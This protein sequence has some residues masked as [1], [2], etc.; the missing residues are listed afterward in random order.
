MNDRSYTIGEL[1]RRSGI[2][3]R[4]IRFYAD[5]GLLSPDRTEARYRVFTDRDLV[6][7]DLIRA[8]RDAGAGLPAI[9]SVIEEDTSL[10]ELLAVRLADVEA[11]ILRQKALAV[12]LRLAL[13]S[14]QPT[15][16][17]IQ[18]ISRMIGHSQSQRHA[19]ATAFL[20]TMTDGVRFDPRWHET[21]IE[22]IAVPALPDEPTP[23]QIDAWLEVN[24]L[25]S[26]ERLQT[27]L[28]AQ[29]IDTGRTLGRLRVHDD[30]DTWRAKERA[31]LDRARAAMREGA[32]ADS[33]QGRQLADDHIAFMAWNRGTTDDAAFRVGIRDLW[34]DDSMLDRFWQQIGILN[35]QP[36]TALPEYEWLAA[37]T[38][39]RLRNSH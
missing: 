6:V 28:R 32:A 9:R 20:D 16:Q 33:M 31:L 2:S 17:D 22:L 36:H 24:A 11:S 4:K 38:R 39:L 26:D 37:A 1:S 13:A 21:M 19:T 25:L 34:Q 8:L 3:T 23:A 5:A 10:S 7:L 15:L 27:T 12:T 35:G 29:A 18:R 14:E 30:L